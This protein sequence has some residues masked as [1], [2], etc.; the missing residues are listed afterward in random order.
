MLFTDD[1]LPETTVS[2]PVSYRALA[3]TYRSRHLGELVGQ[4]VLVKT[5]T[6]ALETGR[7]HHAYLFTGVR[8]VGKT[9]TARIIAKA[10]NYVGADGLGQPTAGPT[11][12]CPVCQAIHEGR[13]P[14]VIEMDA[15]SHTGVDDVRE[16]IESVRYAPT[17][18]R[19]KVYIIDEVHMLSRQAFNALLKTLEEPPPNTLFVFAT[20]EVRKIPV[21]ILSRCQRFDLKRIDI[22]TLSTHYQKIC[23]LENVDITPE[24]LQL[25]ARA[26]EGSARDG[27]SLLDQAMAQNGGQQITAE[28]VQ[29]M[30][31]M[32][33]V[34][35]LVALLDQALQGNAEAVLQ[36]LQTLYTQGVDPSLASA[37]LLNLTH[38]AAKFL[39]QKGGDI[40]HDLPPTAF[41]ALLALTAQVPLPVWSRTWQMLLK[42]HAEILNAPHP[43]AA[44]EMVLL[45]LCFSADLPPLHEL[46]A[47]LPA[48]NTIAA[49]RA[50]S[51]NTAPRTPQGNGSNLA[52]AVSTDAVAAPHVS[53]VPVALKIIEPQ[54]YTLP[55]LIDLCKTAGE[56]M[57]A[58]DL[59]YNCRVLKLQPQRLDVI[60]T[61][62]ASKDFVQKLRA[63]LSQQTGQNW[64]VS[65]SAPQPGQPLPPTWAESQ[66]AQKQEKISALE[67]HPT[68]ATWRSKL[69]KFTITDLTEIKT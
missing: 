65:V 11:D 56:P 33:D 62:G 24:A 66:K 15:A 18:A 40:Q 53:E 22:P 9:S 45:R 68:I 63:T 1:A 10:V 38:A 44:L 23:A 51:T 5:L 3:R 31:G 57:V 55:H 26:A 28:H 48:D 52:Y 21:T 36:S 50:P 29:N 54:T 43:Q 60:L 35:S 16:I 12:D 37:E 61:A 7:I 30:L 13:H 39:V 49:P 67:T 20:T 27:L 46:L 32:G 25:I 42:G 2:K 69:P 59:L 47:N 4:D 8:G 19:Y 6:N 17:S 64:L 58:A 41:A 34:A 14:D